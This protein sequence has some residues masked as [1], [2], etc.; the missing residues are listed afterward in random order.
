MAQGFL[1]P[2]PPP[3]Q[4]TYSRP[5]TSATYVP[6]PGSFGPG[7]GIPPFD[8]HH[9]HAYDSQGTLP[10]VDRQRLPSNAPYDQF[11]GADP[12]VY[13]RDGNVP[14]TPLG[15]P[16]S[17]GVNDN[18]HGIGSPA[19]GMNVVQ[20]Q[21]PQPVNQPPH[22]N[23]NM[24]A[25]EAAVQ[26]P[27]ERILSW[28]AKNGF[29]RDWQETFKALNLQGADF[30]ELGHGPNGRPNLNKMHNVVYPQLAKAC[31][32]SGTGW[33]EPREREEGRRMRRL[34][35]QIQDDGNY[36]AVLPFYKRRESQVF[37]DGVLDVSPKLSQEPTSAGPGGNSPSLKSSPLAHHQKQN[38]QWS[39]TTPNP[40]SHDHQIPETIPNEGTGTSHGRSDFSRAALSNIEGDHRRHTSLSSDNGIFPFPSRGYE[41]SPKS[42]SPA[43]HYPNHLNASSSAN[44]L[45][46]KRE[47]SRGNSSD[48][49]SGRRY[50]ENYKQESSRLSPQ[51]ARHPNG[52]NSASY[53]REQGKGFRLRFMKKSKAGDSNHPSPEE[54]FLESPTSPRYNTTHPYTRPNF[55]SSDVS[56]GERPSSASV[57]DHERLPMKAR[58][59]Q[60]GKKWAFVTWDGFNYRLIDITDIDSVVRLRATI[61]QHIGISDWPAA[62]IFETEPGQT[63]HDSPLNDT[64]LAL[65][66]RTKSDAIG[67]LKLYV[68]GPH[69]N[70][71]AHNYAGLG[72]SIPE[73]ITA[74]P[75]RKPLDDDA[76]S[77]ISPHNQAKPTSPQSTLRPQQL[78]SHAAKVPVRDVSQSSLGM[79][80]VDGGP[81]AAAASLDPETADL[82]A[83][84][85]E[86]MRDVERKQKQN[87]ISNVQPPRKDAYS[88]TG[89]RRE[90][91]IDFDTP[92]VS[93][94]EEDRKAETLVPFRNPP[95]APNESSTLTKLNS[96]RRRDSERPRL[97]QAQAP[98]THQAQQAQQAQQTH[99]THGL[100]A[101]LASVGK[102]TS[103]IGTPSPSARS[104]KA[105]GSSNHSTPVSDSRNAVLFPQ[106]QPT[107]GKASPVVN[108]FAPDEPKPTLQSRKS[109][110]PEFDFEETRVSFQRSPMLPEESD[111]DS[112]DGLFAVPLANKSTP[113]KA[114][115]TF[116]TAN[117]QQTPRKPSLTV[118]TDNNARKKLSVSFRSPSASRETFAQSSG[119]SGNGR[120]S[121]SDM[122]GS[123]ED[124]KPRRDSFARDV[125]ASRPPVEG[126]IDHLDDFFPDIDLDAPYLD[127][128]GPSPPSSPASRAAA[129]NEAAHREKQD[130]PSY[131]TPSNPNAGENPLGSNEP[132]MT[133]QDPGIVARRN[134]NRSSGGVGGGGGGGGGGLTRM[135]S[136]R[137]VAK[138]ANQSNRNR[139]VYAP[140]GSQKSG[141][142]LRRKSTKMFGGRIMQISPKPG[143]RL[144]RLDPIPQNRAASGGPP[145][146]QPTFRIIRGQL[147]GKGTY[148]RVFLGMN[149]DNGEVLAVKQV[150]INP[151]IAG[152]DRDRI[153]EMVAA[154][155][156]EIDTMQHL[157]HPNIVQYLGCERGELSI[158]IYLEYISGGSI[159]SCL[160]K[161]GKF[162]ESVVKSLTRQTLDG[163]SYLHDRG[164]LHRDLKAD[165]IL[166][167]LDG[168]CKISDFGISKKTD[169]IYGNDSTNSMQGSVFWMAPEVIHSQGQGYSAK[170]D[171][172]SLGCVVLEMFAGRRPWSR[173]EAI[174][175][176][177]KLGSLSQA[178]PIPEDVSINISPAALAFM[179]DCF[180]V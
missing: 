54:L 44:D 71:G 168:S 29:S 22:N 1:P 76:R 127:G 79:S 133:P 51:E 148:G 43:T 158:S 165:N 68:R 33:D 176:I 152:Q 13:K 125:W 175:A 132:T 90:G 39:A 25:S 81:E 169:N 65:S 94:Y 178:P 61:C 124:E 7:V 142:I 28:L 37:Q 64:D 18:I 91:V 14:N 12:V 103:A 118:K 23:N 157:E 10:T 98:Q 123:P 104:A 4:P 36:D 159:G 140:A 57:S 141:D 174:G 53:P 171:I 89:Y 30:L 172:W 134:I 2:P 88:E 75:K 35:R 86:H 156:Q 3:P 46:M 24:S 166:L 128:Q 73:K 146:R 180:T 87:R 48:S 62:Q 149:A 40:T 47:H 45:T 11:D 138:G 153:K 160:R 144:N 55:N 129:E 69:V 130:G 167:D 155:D 63:E 101:M 5:A 115:E 131:P 78:R 21:Q 26:W 49:T 106:E 119:D 66:Q 136:I 151:R 82:A 77:R 126:V 50:Y 120:E 20:N 58:P 110:G 31:G 80:P 162:E 111:D 93:P 107:S 113:T 42:S 147:I 16:S 9:M 139:S 100:G 102:M 97:Q 122:T 173:E 161:H 177:F 145:Q 96:L 6:T 179:Y 8:L 163:L 137:E 85:E 17:A 112:D 105:S 41:D 60:K 114:T 154:M 19:Q 34:I 108:D 74:S 67:S 164:I 56:V 109:Y 99:G 52:D 72:V 27:L 70:P 170:V 117:S 38:A 84:Q 116:S 95:T 15:Q 32:I 92:R 143:R 135:K 59:A 150:E 83:R 121:L